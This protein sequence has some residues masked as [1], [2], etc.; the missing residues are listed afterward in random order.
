MLEFEK[1]RA[2]L[3]NTESNDNDRA[4]GDEGLAVGRWQMHPAFVW[5]F[6]P[7]VVTVRE[8]WDALFSATLRNFWDERSRVTPDGVKLAMEFHLGVT[9]VRDGQWDEPY[10]QRFKGFY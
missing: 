4:W 7:D 8:S 2:A 1:W 5:D 10:A 9:A 3:A 6:G